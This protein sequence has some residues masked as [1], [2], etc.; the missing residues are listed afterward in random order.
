MMQETLTVDGESREKT[1]DLLKLWQ[2]TKHYFLWS[3]QKRIRGELK[4]QQQHRW[5]VIVLNVCAVC[6][7]HNNCIKS[8]HLNEWWKNLYRALCYVQRGTIHDSMY[9]FGLLVDV[10][11]HD[12]QIYKINLFIFEWNCRF[13]R[14]GET[15][16][17]V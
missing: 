11:H 14:G 13:F 17:F 7:W 9:R 12:N 15:F 10:R 6:T 1:S 16:F 5:C 8:E 3:K 2:V 4:K